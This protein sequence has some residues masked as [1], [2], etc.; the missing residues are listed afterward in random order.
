MILLFRT[1]CADDSATVPPFALVDITL[2]SAV[3]LSTR[4]AMLEAL[5]EH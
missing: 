5:R 1:Y 3:Q 4:M 2:H